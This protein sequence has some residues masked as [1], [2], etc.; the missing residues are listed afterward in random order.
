MMVQMT[1]TSERW[2]R[3]AGEIVQ[4]VHETSKSDPRELSL[5]VSRVR[6]SLQGEDLGTAIG[7]SI[8]CTG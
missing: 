6:H 1:E 8:T 4:I 3:G 7:C 5:V 2:S